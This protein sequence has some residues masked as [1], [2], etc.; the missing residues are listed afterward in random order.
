MRLYGV[1]R[2]VLPVEEAIYVLSQY[3]NLSYAQNIITELVAYPFR[4]SRTY[5]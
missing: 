1:L 2:A 4:N 5:P 3:G